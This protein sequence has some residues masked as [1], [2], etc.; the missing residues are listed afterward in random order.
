MW[1][2]DAGSVQ[3]YTWQAVALAVPQKSFSGTDIS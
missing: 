3:T 2:V 1:A